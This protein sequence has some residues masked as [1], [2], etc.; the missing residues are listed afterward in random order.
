MGFLERIDTILN[1]SE[2]RESISLFAGA[3]S[4]KKEIKIMFDMR[5]RSNKGRN[6]RVQIC[7]AMM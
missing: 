3:I 4:T 5:Q 2:L 6:H 7:V 1:C